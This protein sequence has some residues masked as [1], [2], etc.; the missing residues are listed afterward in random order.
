MLFDRLGET[1]TRI[2]AAMRQDQRVLV[3]DDEEMIGKVL[4]RLL[5]RE[6]FQVDTVTSVPQAWELI[7]SRPYDLCIA[8]KNIP[9][10]GGLELIAELQEKNIDLPSVL[11]TA[12]PS[13]KSIARALQSGAV[14]FIEKP[15]P[16]F[17][18]LVQRL[19]A[20]VQQRTCQRFYAQVV[21]DLSQVFD[22]DRA[23]QQVLKDIARDLGRFKRLLAQR[24]DLALVATATA[25]SQVVEDA[26]NVANLKVERIADLPTLQRRLND[27]NAPL[28]LVL[29]SKLPGLNDFLRAMRDEAPL[30]EALVLNNSNVDTRAALDALEAGALDFVDRHAEG[31][32]VLLQRAQRMAKQVR[33]RHLYGQ[34]LATLVHHAQLLGQ[35]I[36][37]ALLQA[38]PLAQQHY[39]L[40]QG[41]QLLQQLANLPETRDDERDSSLEQLFHQ[42]PVRSA[43]RVNA[44]VA[45]QTKPGALAQDDKVL[46][47][48]NISESGM[49]ISSK[50][51]LPIG[52]RIQLEVADPDSFQERGIPVVGEVVRSL[53]VVPDPR[54]MSGIGLRVVTA[55]HGY[56][57]L[58]GELLEQFGPAPEVPP[59]LRAHA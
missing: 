36:P 41:P 33:R 3:V 20:I 35:E 51:Q 23:D 2:H 7:N 59:E 28:A 25:A 30:V 14:D 37:A 43:K 34:L 26:L 46:V 15:F 27:P 49:F 5:S 47:T 19:S 16:N 11:I 53:N 17:R 12:K 9:G 31:L 55:G 54:G 18:Q 48:R 8:D 52:T 57:R 24:S 22:G 1:W 4:A 58:V 42:S 13:A 32:E 38:L 40:H 21:R 10:Q 39:A 50:T 45:L 44:R 56:V 6:G 29:D